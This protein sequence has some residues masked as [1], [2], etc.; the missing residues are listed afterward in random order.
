MGANRDIVD[1]YFL[2]KPGNNPEELVER[3]VNRYPGRPGLSRTQIVSALVGFEQKA[4]HRETDAVDTI[5]NVPWTR[6]RIQVWVVATVNGG[7]ANSCL[8]NCRFVVTRVN[9]RGIDTG[10]KTRS[11]NGDLAEWVGHPDARIA[12]GH[13]CTHAFVQVA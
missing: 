5:E 1:V 11:R 3:P 8:L 4:S 6:I 12:K 2:L 13:C 10:V 9:D 7:H